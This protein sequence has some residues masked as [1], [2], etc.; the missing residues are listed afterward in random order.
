MIADG[1]PVLIDL[2]AVRKFGE[3]AEEHTRFYGLDADRLCVDP[4]F[5]LCCIFVTLAQCFMSDFEVKHRKRDSLKLSMENE[6]DTHINRHVN[7][8]VHLF[9]FKSCGLDHEILVST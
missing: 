4:L 5:D 3:T 8:C 7:I 1:E 9:E 6:K 2:G